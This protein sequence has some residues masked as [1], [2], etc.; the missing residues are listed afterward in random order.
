MDSLNIELSNIPEKYVV[1]RVEMDSCEAIADSSRF[2]YKIENYL[3]KEIEDKKV[4]CVPYFCKNGRTG[5]I[6]LV[7]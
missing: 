3:Q 6:E 2:Y 1:F 5:Y 7:K 4:L